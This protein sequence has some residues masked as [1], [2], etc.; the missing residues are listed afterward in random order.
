MKVRYCLLECSLFTT[1][2][3]RLLAS[4]VSSPPLAEISIENCGQTFQF[5]SIAFSCLPLAPS[6]LPDPNHGLPTGNSRVATA[7]FLNIILDIGSS[8]SFAIEFRLIG[9]D[10]KMDLAVLVWKM[11]VQNRK[12][13]EEKHPDSCSGATWHTPDRSSKQRKQ[14]HDRRIRTGSAWRFAP[15]TWSLR[16]LLDRLRV[17]RAFFALPPTHARSAKQGDTLLVCVE[18]IVLFNRTF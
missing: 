1:S 16:F 18:V 7:S 11:T 9:S 13:A 8:S 5:A 15:A 2:T 10:L 4:I 6:L 12:L 3:S 17:A 14:G